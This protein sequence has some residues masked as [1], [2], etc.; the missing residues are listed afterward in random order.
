[1]VLGYNAYDLAITPDNG[2][3]IDHNCY[4]RLDNVCL[5]NACADMCCG[6]SSC[7]QLGQIFRGRGFG[8]P[9]TSLRDHHW[10]CGSPRP[11]TLQW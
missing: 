7:K 1:M 11:R 4:Q 6:T 5:N 8:E 9:K 2:L 3:I 10:N